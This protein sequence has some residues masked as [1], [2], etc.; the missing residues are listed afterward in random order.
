MSQPTSLQ[1]L[2]A[3]IWK[4]FDAEEVSEPEA[5]YHALAPLLARWLLALAEYPELEVSLEL[6]L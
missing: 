2:D 1:L 3:A 5:F 4:E 6:Y